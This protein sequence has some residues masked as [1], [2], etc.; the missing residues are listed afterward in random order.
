MHR[1]GGIKVGG[2]H[3]EEEDVLKEK[4]QHEKFAQKKERGNTEEKWE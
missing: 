1:G 2:G 3:Q 4:E